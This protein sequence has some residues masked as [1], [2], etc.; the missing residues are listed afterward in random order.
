HPK[1]RRGHQKVRPRRLPPPL[2]QRWEVPLP[3]LVP[4]LWLNGS[5]VP[6]AQTTNARTSTG[7]PDDAGA[8]EG[9]LSAAAATGG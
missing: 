1:A 6:T 9:G 4:Q 8:A 7:A 5:A 3:P 2:P